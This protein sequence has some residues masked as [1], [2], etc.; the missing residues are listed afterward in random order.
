MLNVQLI[1][2]IPFGVGV[3]VAGG[4]AMIYSESRFI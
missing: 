2:V 4:N 1:C 3:W